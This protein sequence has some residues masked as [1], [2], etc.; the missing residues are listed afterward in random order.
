MT[1]H[2]EV[3]VDEH[4]PGRDR[5]ARRARRRAATPTRRPP[6]GSCRPRSSRR[7][8]A[9]VPASMP[10]TMLPV[11][12][13]TPSRSSAR[14]AN[15]DSG[16]RIGAEHV[17]AALDQ[18][19]ARRLGID[20]AE[21]V[22]QRVARDLGQRAGQL[23]AGRSAADDDERQQPALR[24]SI[25]VSRSACSNASSTRRRMSSASSSVFRPGACALP[26]VVAEI[27][28]RRARR[29]DQV[30]VG[31]LAVGEL[32]DAAR[33]IDRR[34]P[35]RATPA[36]SAGGAE[37]SGSAT[38]CRRATGRRSRPDTAA[39]ERRDGCAGR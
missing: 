22:G 12:T 32:H 9:R 36:R 29:D 4:A 19:D 7:R 26:L 15:A 2:R 28:V 13:A 17:R 1:R 14:R 11:H 21:V 8:R 25:R 18:D 3:V 24:G 35:R 33:R 6:T 37:S 38:R 31:D 39:A 27:G 34:R 30:V 10:V 20:R 16:V 23:H 5:A